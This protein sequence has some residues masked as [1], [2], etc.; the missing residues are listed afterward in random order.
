MIFNKS[1]DFNDRDSEVVIR[2]L[3]VCIQVKDS[4]TDANIIGDAEAHV[5]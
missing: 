4:Y 1:N 3:L 2:K 5:K